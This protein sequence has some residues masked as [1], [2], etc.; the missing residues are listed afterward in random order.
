MGTTT[1][2]T[3]ITVTEGT[4]FARSVFVSSREGIAITAKT[5]D[6]EAALFW[7]IDWL[8]DQGFRVLRYNCD[9][10]QDR[11]RVEAQSYEL[12]KI[13]IEPVA[14]GVREKLSETGGAYWAT[15]ETL[16]SYW[17]VA[18]DQIMRHP[19]TAT[20]VGEVPDG[21]TAKEQAA[22]LG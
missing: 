10:T 6:P 8:E 17:R 12:P 3:D 21:R 13:E 22:A 2:T 11:C 5:T 20:A 4:P 14:R 7:L 18:P 16:S 15:V 9:S 19:V 1:E